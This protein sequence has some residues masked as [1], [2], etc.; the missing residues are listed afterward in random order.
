[1][2]HSG[3]I[4]NCFSFTSIPQLTSCLECAGCLT[5]VCWIGWCCFEDTPVQSQTKEGWKNFSEIKHIAQW[6]LSIEQAGHVLTQTGILH[7]LK[8]GCVDELE[9]Q[10]IPL[11]RWIRAN[12]WRAFYALLITV[13]MA[14]RG[15][16]IPV[17]DSISAQEFSELIDLILVVLNQ[18]EC[19]Y[20]YHRY[21]KCYN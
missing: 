19:E 9:S 1:M 17:Y 8:V 2:S 4:N 12:L 10:E 6:Q 15:R 3:N 18:P 21:H 7:D 14:C 13:A 5:I 16:L 11:E 20:L